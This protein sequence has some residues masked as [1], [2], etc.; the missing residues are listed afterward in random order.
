MHCTPVHVHNSIRSQPNPMVKR[1][2]T[3]RA[4]TTKAKYAK[5][6]VRKTTRMASRRIPRKTIR[7]T[8]K[9]SLFQGVRQLATYHSVSSYSH[10]VKPLGFK[11]RVFNASTHGNWSSVT[12]AKVK[13]LV[14]RQEAVDA[15]ILDANDIGT[16]KAEVQKYMASGFSNVQMNAVQFLLRKFRVRYEIKNFSKDSAYIDIYETLPRRDI[17][18]D[19]NGSPNTPT[20]AWQQGVKDQVQVFDTTMYG[21]PGQTPFDSKQFTTFYHVRKVTRVI[22]GPGATHEHVVSGTPNY[23]FNWTMNVGTSGQVL[24]YKGLTANTMFVVRGSIGLADNATPTY[25]NCEIAM[26]GS[27][28]VEYSFTNTG[29]NVTS[30]TYNL[31]TSLFSGINMV[32][33]NTSDLDTYAT[34]T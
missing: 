12:Q 28:E 15:V 19:D 13:S 9:A 3:K 18:I 26:I 8:K 27:K 22:L 2:Y 16:I 33:P 10:G 7:R 23:L 1:T 24:A 31:A 14:G 4:K 20:I 21:K 6:G 5:K 34:V 25:E 30:N 11:A 32:N 29:A 17:A